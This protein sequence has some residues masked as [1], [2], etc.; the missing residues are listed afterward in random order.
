MT[1]DLVRRLRG[2]YCIPITDGLGATGGGEEPDNPNE[3]VRRFET[4]LIQRMA[5]DEIERLTA[6]AARLAA[7]EQRLGPE[8]IDALLA[9]PDGSKV[10]VV[11]PSDLDSK[12]WRGI[13]K[14]C[15]LD[16]PEP[17]GAPATSKTQALGH[18]TRF[19]DASSFDEVCTACGATDARGD[20]RLNQPCPGV[21][22]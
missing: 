7:L 3:F 1:D 17:A 5:A 21:A 14:L 22:P 15:R 13:I 20:D 19:S 18:T 12:V 4:P 9:D 10:A 2:E 6:Q 8:T 11:R 16:K